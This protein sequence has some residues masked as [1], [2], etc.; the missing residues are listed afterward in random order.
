MFNPVL[1]SNDYRSY[2]IP[3][4]ITSGRVHPYSAL[5][6]WLR[7]Q[8]EVEPLHNRTYLGKALS[9]RFTK[10]MKSYLRAK[11]CPRSEISRNASWENLSSGPMESF[12]SH[13]GRIKRFEGDVCIVG[14]CEIYR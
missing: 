3:T 12:H 14:D 5:Y 6:E 4:H 1:S 13:T 10:A 2:V 7:E 11:G 9:V 8:G